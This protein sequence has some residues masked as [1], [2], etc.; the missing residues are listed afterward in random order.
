MIKPAWEWAVVLLPQDTQETKIKLVR[1]IREELLEHVAEFVEK[2]AG[3]NEHELAEKIK[4]L[5]SKM[6]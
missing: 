1:R 4:G 2:K 5:K 6:L 3:Y